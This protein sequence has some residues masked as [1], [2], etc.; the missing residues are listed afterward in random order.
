RPAPE[1]TEVAATLAHGRPHRAARAVAVGRTAEELARS[2]GAPAP[3]AG[4]ETG[5]LAFAYPGQGGARRGMA[6]GLW[7]AHPAARRTL[8]RCGALYAR[9]FDG[10]LLAPL[11]HGDAD[12]PLPAASAQAALYAHQAALTAAWR[13]AGIEPA[14]VFGHSVGEFAALHAAGALTLE[15]GLRLTAW[16]GRATR[17]HAP[18]GGMLVLLTDPSTALRLAEATGT[19]VA[20]HNG[21]GVQVVAGDPEALGELT[22]RCAD[23]RV[24]HRALPV[25]RAFHS[26]AMELALRAFR[27]LAAGV[28][29]RP[30]RLPSL[31]ATD[32][33]HRPAGWRVD[34]DHLCRQGRQ[35]VRFDLVLATA[36]RLGYRDFVEAGAGDA[37]TGLGRAATPESR[38]LRGQGAGDTAA[39]QAAGLLASLGA[40]H[41]AG[42]EL[43]WPALVPDVGRVPLPGHPQRRTAVPFAATRRRAAAPA[44]ATDPES[45][46]A[47]A[48]ESAPATD[49]E[50]APA[51][52]PEE[53]LASVRE[54]TADKLGRPEA[55]IAP[56]DSFLALGADSL[57]LMGLTAAL[58]RRHGVRV[59]VRELFDSVDTPRALAA[60]LAPEGRRPAAPTAVTPVT[61]KAPEPRTAPAPAGPSARVPAEP[62]VP[63]PASVPVPAPVPEEG[64][65]A[66]MARQLRLM[67]R[68]ADQVGEVIGRQLD[69]LGGASTAPAPASVPAPAPASVPVPASAPVTERAPAPV[70]QVPTPPGA[71]DVS[72]YFFGDYPEDDAHDKYALIMEA[73][74]FADRNGFHALWFPERHFASF[75]A[76]FPNPSVLAAALAARTSRVRLHAGSVVLPL[77]HPVRVAEEWSVVD[78]VSGGRVGLC[79]ASGW[80]ATDF[81]LAP[82]N[83]G[84][85]REVMYEHL[86]TVRSLWAGEAVTT[87]SGDGQPVDVRLHPAPVQSDPPMYA[88]VV[89]NPDSYRRAAAEGLGVVTN[90]MTQTVERLAENIARY[91]AARAEHGLDPAGGRVVVLMHTYLA[92]DDAD[93]RAEA[94]RPFLNYLRS[95]LSLLNQVTNSL[96]FEVDLAN[97]PEEDVE[98]LLGRA[99]ADYCDSRALI[100]DREA[101]L[102]T[103]RRLLAAGADEIACF[104]D[105][106]VDKEKVLAALPLVDGLRRDLAAE[107]APT[108]GAPA[109]TAPP[110]APPASAVPAPAAPPAE[111][112]PERLPLTPAQRRLWFLERLHPGTHM[113]HEPKAVHLEGPLDVPALRR[114][115]DRVAARQPALRTVFGEENGVPHREVR[116]RMPFDVPVEEHPGLDVARAVTAALAAERG[117]VLDTA[118]GPLVTARLLR[119]SEESHLLFLMAHHLV[120]DSASTPV[121]VSDLVA[122]YRAETGTSPGAVPLPPLPEV[123]RP[124]EPSA[125]ERAAA[126]D[127]WVRRLAGAPELTLPTDRPRPPVRTGVGA[128]VSHAWDAELIAHVREFAASHGATLFMALTGALSAVLAR[129]AGQS[130]IVVGT[131]VSARPEGAEGHVGFFL[132]TVPLRLD[133][134]GDPDLPTLLRRVR[135][136][137]TEALDH[138]GVPFDELVG[139][140]NPTRDPGRNPLF[141]VLVEYENEGTV[142]SDPGG[143]RVTLLDVPSDR[144]PFD[145]AFYLTHHPGGVRVAVE[146]DTALLEAA[147]VRRLLDRVEALLRRAL[148]DPAAPLAALT[149]VPDAERAALARLG[150]LDEPAP[151]VEDTLHGLFARQARRAPGATALVHGEH[152]VS[153]GELADRVE[154]LAARLRAAGAGRG[155]RVAVLLPRG[156]ELITAL[157]GVLTSGAAYVPLDPSA[158]T[159]RLAELL[160]DGEPCALLCDAATLEAHPAL[161]GTVPLVPLEA[162]GDEPVEARGAP[163]PAGP[164]DP[165]YCLHTSGSTGRPKAVVVPHRGPVNLVLAHLEAHPAL[166]TLQWTA[167]VF[168]VHVQEVFT[169]LAAGATLV[170]IDDAARRDPV[171]VA[172]TVR[173]H[174]VERMFLPSTPLRH[175]L[176]TE[177]RLPTLRELFTAG[178]AL[179][180]TDGVRGFLDRHPGCTLYHQYGPTEASV[181]VTSQR[182][183]PGA[184]DPWPPIG[185][186]VPGARLRLLD[187]AG[188]PVPLGAVGELHVGGVPVAAGYLGRPEETAAAFLDDGTGA[189]T[190]RTGDLAR[191]RA[192]GSLQYRGRIDDQTKIRG[193]RVEPGEVRAALT[194][195]PWVADAAVVARRD[196]HGER[197]LFACV[198]PAPGADGGDPL[199]RSREALAVLLPDPLVPR[200][201]A[202]LSRLPVNASGK[203]DRKALPEPEA[204][205][206]PGVDDDEPATPLEKALR[207]LWAEELGVAHVPVTRSF[208]ALGGH[209]LSAVR[210]LHRVARELELTLSMAEFFRTPTVRGVAARGSAQPSEVTATVPM[211]AVQ[212]RLWRRHHERADAGCYHVTHRVDLRGPVRPERLGAWLAALVERH[213]ALRTR[214]V[215]R[216][217]RRLVEVLDRVAVEL[218]VD[219]LDSG[220]PVADADVE[221]WCLRHAGRPF[222]LE[223]APLFRF[224]LARTGPDRWSLLTVFHHAVCDGWSLGVL[225]RD[226]GALAHAAEG[227]GA[228]ELPPPGGQFPAVARAEA[229]LAGERRAELERFWRDELAGAPLDLALPTDRP[230]PPVLSG[231]GALHTRTL[232]VTLS[233]ALPGTAT[234]LG[235][236][237]YAVLAAAFA[238]WAARRTGHRDDVVLNAS[239]A[240]RLVPE[241][242]DVVG[243]LG[244]AVALRARLSDA[245]TVADLARQLGSGLFAALDHQELPLAEVAELVAPGASDGAFPDVLFTVVTTPPPALDLPELTADV[246]PLPLPGVSRNALYVV[247]VPHESGLEVTFEYATDLFEPATVA[248]WADELTALLRQVVTDPDAPLAPLLGP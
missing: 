196:R 125:A 213:E 149:A 154:R 136:R 50:S 142:A 21:P 209:S 97:S 88:A 164:D 172:E 62:P 162:D 141:Q 228:P 31:T 121:L 234:R 100:G 218:P 247:L 181:I 223:H 111:R 78:N 81:A 128:S 82:E 46:P 58:E 183:D 38:W 187:P 145:L 6:A 130:E 80:H 135:E 68:L 63:V 236:T 242:A 231:R 115:L 79:F 73:A 152:H 94:R 206:V 191:W 12:E 227:R 198:V 212:R 64:P 132:D 26:A 70:A 119:L 243:L 200:R 124:A 139:A 66:L 208:F 229:A 10:E 126:L 207:E 93:A 51:P 76:L 230:R 176:D 56:D 161:A 37:L 35:P 184:D 175:L 118:E 43:N 248:A 84:R 36:A 3:E 54:L 210:L 104:V 30:L 217:G 195:L 75:G 179:Q 114:A 17:E 171:E 69:V 246:R 61:A 163:D 241:R 237:P 170:L 220:A 106:G 92:E 13:A 193:H 143:P 133:L 90:L 2:L 1:A 138:R 203:L 157:L 211:N 40:L 127:H 159:P 137:G 33:V 129:H 190:Y 168:D 235:T 34:L 233:R 98:F 167:P 22:R 20:A 148:A 41:R 144:A 5:R 60:R 67:E 216:G 55:E 103:A 102:A 57:S 24:P 151:V 113:Y 16:R 146:Y 238:V 18:P 165:A 23:E 189:A 197:E 120:F 52:V 96:G 123:P 109:G 117:R 110:K 99:Y 177:P 71:C 42:A 201:W 150:R 199:A 4:R 39:E 156:P 244:D 8:E 224:R 27:A 116:A 215:V 221:R 14:L 59:P 155:R 245:G 169:T 95:S 86:A 205:P 89:G 28:E 15:D 192:D 9:E 186:P 83:F 204:E 194:A 29:L 182:V 19:T 107:P 226:L 131:A 239:S 178:E 32:G 122:Y 202:R 11:L 91:R 173:R 185:T 188:R 112:P 166:R 240:N 47:P 153:Y 72:L 108:R 140:L 174:A 160:A 158:P 53:L 219:E 65:H 77:H 134:T 214:L 7:A 74:E 222:D 87:A 105:F 101:A 48:P 180:L 232:E 147:T 49:P 225:W 44:P 25:D 85:H 45:A